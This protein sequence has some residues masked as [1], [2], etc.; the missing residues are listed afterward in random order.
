M[1]RTQ[2]DMGALNLRAAQQFHT[3]EG[4]LRVSRKHIEH[5]ERAAEDT[6]GPAD[7][8]AGAGEPVGV[9]LG[10]WLDTVHERADKLAEQRRADRDALGMRW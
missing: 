7:R 9:K 8:P 6:V 5:L 3:R 1:R 4:H 2:D 10:A